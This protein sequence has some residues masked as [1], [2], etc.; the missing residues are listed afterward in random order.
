MNSVDSFVEKDI[1]Q[2]AEH[3]ITIIETR[4]YIFIDTIGILGRRGGVTAQKN[5]VWHPTC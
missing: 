4:E 5:G 2:L 3:S 1:N